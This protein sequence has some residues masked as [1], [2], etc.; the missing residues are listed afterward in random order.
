[1][2][3]GVRDRARGIE[4]ADVRHRQVRSV[5]REL[6]VAVIEADRIVDGHELGPVRESTLDLNLVNE[7]RD[8]RED[9]SLAE[10]LAPDVHQVGDGAIAV[11]NELE[12]LR[13]EERDGLGVVQAQT[14]R[15][16]LLGE[17]ASAVENELVDV[18]R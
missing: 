12:E 13:R 8:A 4:D 7:A 15:E 10:H 6:E 17:A 14:A 5:E 18:A 9:L 11:A 2:E 3:A 16:P 1:M